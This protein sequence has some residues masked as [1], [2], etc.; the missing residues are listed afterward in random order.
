MGDDMLSCWLAE[1]CMETSSAMGALELARDC[2]SLE[3][4]ALN[5][6]RGYHL[7]FPELTAW[8]GTLF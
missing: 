8:V 6:R 1:Y 2:N 3:S 5:S 7:D 4:V